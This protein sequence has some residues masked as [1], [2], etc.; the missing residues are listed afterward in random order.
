VINIGADMEL[1][2][3]LGGGV[4]WVVGSGQSDRC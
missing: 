3:L 4:R 1:M 2:D